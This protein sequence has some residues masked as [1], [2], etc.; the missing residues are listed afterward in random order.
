MFVALTSVGRLGHAHA[1]SGRTF[2]LGWLMLVLHAPS[3]LAQSRTI[4]VSLPPSPPPSH[5]VYPGS[6]ALQ[7]ALDAASSGD[8]LVL[9]DGT[10]TGSGG[11]MLN[12]GKD[13]TIRAQNAGQAILDGQ[14]TRR[15]IRITGGA[16]LLDGLNITNG[17]A[18]SARLVAQKTFPWAGERTLSHLHSPDLNTFPPHQDSLKPLCS[19]PR[20]PLPNGLRLTPVCFL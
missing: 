2:L 17:H 6:G 1:E 19:T 15:V 5:L 12:I 10:Y 4:T 20:R 16:V 9:A 8:E 3:I 11:T 13:I 7:A 18:V 14:S